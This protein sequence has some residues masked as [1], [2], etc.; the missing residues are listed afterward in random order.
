VSTSAVTAPAMSRRQVLESLSGLLVAMFV[1]MLASTVVSTSLPKIVSELGGDQS[2]FTWVITASLLATTVS[3]PI[4]GKLADLTSRKVLVQVAIVVFVIGTILSGLAP[5]AGTLIAFRVVQGL[6]AGGLMAL[7]QVILSDIISPRERGKYM[8]LMGG[9]MAVAT[10]GGPLLGGYITDTIGWRWNFFV[11]VPFA[12]VALIL[13]QVTLHLPKRHK[14]VRIDYL[15]AVLIAGG[16]SMLLIW[17]T[18]GGN[19]FEWASLTSW[20]M[21]GG[22]AVLLALAVLVE[23]K[24]PEPIIPLA[25]FKNRT[26]ALMTV[27]SVA[28]GVAM[29]GTSVFISQYLQLSR[30]KTPTESGIY[31]LPQVFAMLIASMIVGNLISRTG[32]WKAWMVTGAALL[33]LGTGLMGTIAYDTPFALLFLF[34]GIIGLGIGMLMQNMVLVVQNTVDVSQIGAASASIAFFRSL[35]GAAGVAALGAALATRVKDGIADG[36]AGLGVPAGATGG[37]GSLPDLATLPAPIRAVIEQ[38]YGDGVG[39][40]FLIA[41]PVAILALVMV[42]LLPNKKLGTR[43][44]I[45][46]LAE[47]QAEIVIDT[48][49]APAS[50]G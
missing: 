13:I 1:A 41:L 16:V 34:M 21:A 37:S 36:L 45:E 23:L 8:G 47:K 42:A 43:N 14:K 30:D 50:R 27:A 39:E 49:P 29:F 17:V 3:T 7:V 32:K 31:T 18:L 5:D 28:V 40:I 24:H 6:G 10:A 15:G 25:L 19:Q 26:F 9:I 20:L 38:A 44:G 35:G 12:I 4:W 48:D 2:A 11:A 22:S 46:Q 33:A